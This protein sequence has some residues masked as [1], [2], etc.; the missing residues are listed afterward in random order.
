MTAEPGAQPAYKA[1]RPA[2]PAGAGPAVRVVSVTGE[3]DAAQAAR[4]EAAWVARAIV[5]AGRVPGG[6]QE[7]RRALKDFAVLL[8]SSTALPAF[9]DAFKRAGIPYAVEIER[10]FYEASEVSDFLNLLRALDDPADRVALA[11]LLRSPL[12]ALTDD[13]LLALARAGALDY[14]RDPAARGMPAGEGRRATVL[15]GVLRD[16]EFGIGIFGIEQLR[17]MP[18]RARP[19]VGE[20]PMIVLQREGERKVGGQ[21]VM[22]VAVA[23]RP[24]EEGEVDL[25]ECRNREQFVGMIVARP[26]FASAVADPFDDVASLQCVRDGPPVGARGI[27]EKT[28]IIKRIQKCHAH[29]P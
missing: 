19:L 9:L 3:T 7:G 11:G 16:L 24:Q 6:P 23:A 5:A 10:F 26:D 25:R 29:H 4:A 20:Y 17:A 27:V 1:L 13:G 18:I 14:R 2:R 21:K 22:R 8:R 12:A 15:F 28:D